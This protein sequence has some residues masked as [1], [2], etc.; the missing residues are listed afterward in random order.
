ML[1]L[2]MIFVS[3]LKIES[4]C[5]NGYCAGS[6]VGSYLL[7]IRSVKSAGNNGMFGAIVF[8]VLSSLGR[9]AHPGSWLHL[10][11]RGH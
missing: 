3:I 5:L 8:A 11:F 6:M 4:R 9:F 2:I 7:K 1:E 10:P